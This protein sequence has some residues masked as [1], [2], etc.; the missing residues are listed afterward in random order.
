[1]PFFLVSEVIHFN[2]HHHNN[3]AERTAAAKTLLPRFLNSYILYSYYY[4]KTQTQ[5]Q[6]KNNTS[7]TK[8]ISETLW[9]GFNGFAKPKSFRWIF[10]LYTVSLSTSS[11]DSTRT[12]SKT[13]NEKTQK[14]HGQCRQ[15]DHYVPSRTNFGEDDSLERLIL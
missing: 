1:M 8:H 13:Q 6:Q 5:Q 7:N 11:D 2:H 12:N 9:N 10:V 4:I 15:S 14:L 3:Q